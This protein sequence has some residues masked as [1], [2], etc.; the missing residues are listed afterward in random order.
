DFHVPTNAYYDKLPNTYE[1]TFR[2]DKTKTDSKD[3]EHRKSAVYKYYGDNEFD[4]IVAGHHQ[5]GVAANDWANPGKQSNPAFVT[6]AAAEGVQTTAA[7]GLVTAA[8]QYQTAALLLPDLAQLTGIYTD[9]GVDL[10]NDGQFEALRMTVGINITATANYQLVGWL[11][12]GTGTNLAWA[13][14]SANLS[15]GV[16]QMPLDFDGKLLRL[17]AENG[18]YTL[19]HV[20]IRTGDDGDV[21]D[22]ADHAYTTAAYSAGSFV[23]PPVTYT[24]VYADHGVDSNGNTRFDSLAIDVGVQV[25]SPGTYSLTGWLYAADGS[26]IPGAVATTAFSTSG[27]QTLLFDGKSI[28]WQRK[29]GPYTLRYLEVRNANQE[30]V[31]FLAQ[32]YTTTVTYP[33]TQFESGGAAELDATAYRDQGIDLNGDGLYD[34]LRITT[35]ISATTAGLYQLSAALHDQAGQ[36]IT[37]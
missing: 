33:A 35:S 36:A 10:N 23:A 24:G 28:R 11:Q 3:L 19:V 13:A 7:S 22:A 12:S 4:A 14:T 6:A 29:N 30:R 2:T 16:Q 27:T 31:A 26:A 9:A 20:E 32:A 15:P 25:N 8:S 1:D 21:V 37:T 5:Q 34:A 18:P 17:L